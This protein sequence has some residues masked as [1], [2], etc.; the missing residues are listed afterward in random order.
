MKFV[1]K[2]GGRKKGQNRTTFGSDYTRNEIKIIRIRGSGLRA[3]N[4]DG[5]YV[6]VGEIP[7]CLEIKEG[8]NFGQMEKARKRHYGHSCLC[9]VS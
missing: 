7:Q 4:V 1:H 8:M 9:F 2:Y 3:V 5:S 6:D